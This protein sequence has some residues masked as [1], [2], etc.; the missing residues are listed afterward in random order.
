MTYK[1]LR[2]FL[3]HRE[4]LEDEAGANESCRPGSFDE[5]LFGELMINLRQVP[6]ADL[7]LGEETI[8]NSVVIGYML[9]FVPVSQDNCMEVQQRELVGLSAFDGTEVLTQPDEVAIE[10]DRQ[11]ICIRVITDDIFF[12]FF[13]ELG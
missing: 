11:E 13:I 6:E 7:F 8:E 9:I 3:H 1:M 4:S 10:H 2:D 5:E 12:H